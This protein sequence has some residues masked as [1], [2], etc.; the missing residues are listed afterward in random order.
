MKLVKRKE[1]S[2]RADKTALVAVPIETE[3]G[4]PFYCALGTAGPVMTA[5][6]APPLCSLT[7]L[8]A[9]SLPRSERMAT[10]AASTLSPPASYHPPH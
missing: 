7:S 6:L 9:P 4:L 8:N 5:P 10:L 2:I 1:G 3:K